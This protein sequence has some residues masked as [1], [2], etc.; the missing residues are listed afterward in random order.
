M[1]VMTHSSN[2]TGELYDIDAIGQ[3]AYENHIL[4]CG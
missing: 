2:V 3:I 4:F 1:I